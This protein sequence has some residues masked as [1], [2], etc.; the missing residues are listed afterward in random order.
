M[1]KLVLADGQELVRAGIQRLLQDEDDMDVVAV[2]DGPEEA[3]RYARGHRPD[4]LIISPGERPDA[5]V[6]RGLIVDLAEASP[7]T[8][9]V[10][11][12]N[13]PDARAARDVLRDGALGFVLRTEG[14]DAL[15]EAT[16]RAAKGEPYI[17]ARVGLTDQTAVSDPSSRLWMISS[18]SSR[19]RSIN[20]ATVG[21][22]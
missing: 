3:V 12:S 11:L 17:N 21:M 1:I 5:E 2:A 10:V 9:L 18:A 15:T 14:P 22:S 7:K 20:S 19:I 13:N 6:A 16:R 8:R 4:V